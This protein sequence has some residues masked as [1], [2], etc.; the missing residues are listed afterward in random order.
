MCL[1][2]IFYI[3]I[4]CLPVDRQGIFDDFILLFLD[5]LYIE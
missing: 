4:T 5:F 1:Y 2:F 3:M